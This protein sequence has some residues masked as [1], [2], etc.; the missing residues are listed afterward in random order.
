MQTLHP[1][2]LTPAPTGTNQ[3]FARERLALSE[4]R[5]QHR[6]RMVAIWMIAGAP[7]RIKLRTLTLL[8]SRYN[9]QEYAMA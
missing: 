4:R 7:P 2:D 9:C 5:G 3:I 8:K 6:W 1:D